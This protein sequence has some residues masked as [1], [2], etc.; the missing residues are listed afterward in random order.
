MVS[1][2]RNP[3]VDSNFQE[4]KYNVAG[5]TCESNTARAQSAIFRK[6]DP[7]AFR[8]Q[9]KST[10]NKSIFNSQLFDTSLLGHPIRPL[11]TNFCL[12]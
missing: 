9:S 2:D 5:N 7:R 1:L 3:H 10:N 4:F 8:R 12:S 11:L 6:V